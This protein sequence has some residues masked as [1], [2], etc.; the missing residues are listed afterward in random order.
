MADIHFTFNVALETEEDDTLLGYLA[1]TVK[2]DVTSGGLAPTSGGVTSATDTFASASGIFVPSGKPE[3][4][5]ALGFMTPKREP[6][7]VKPLTT[8]TDSFE[9]VT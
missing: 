2:K 4:G 8:P 3:P 5:K 9:E 7:S 1:S 6:G